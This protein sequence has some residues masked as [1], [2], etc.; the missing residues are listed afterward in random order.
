MRTRPWTVLLIM[1]A[2][3]MNRHQ[4][5]MIEYLRE[6]N[7]ILREKF[8]K[9]RIILNDDQRR[10]L[11]VRGKELGKKLLS[12]VSTIFSPETVLRWHRDLIAR[13][14]DGSGSRKTGT[15]ANI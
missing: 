12:E 6:E 9:R 2:G 8:G 3:W 10:R 11:A 5:D 7:K 15:A 4:Q 1:L 14:Y 13:K